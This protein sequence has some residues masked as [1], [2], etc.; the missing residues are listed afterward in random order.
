M[1]PKAKLSA[2]NA[3]IIATKT[4]VTHCTPFTIMVY[5]HSPTRLCQ[6]S[7]GT[8]QAKANL[9]ISIPKMYVEM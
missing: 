8:N 4:V 2:H 6:M 3:G 7:L 9:W 5:L 1:L